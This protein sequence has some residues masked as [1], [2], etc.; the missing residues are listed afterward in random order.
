MGL[1]PLQYAAANNRNAAV[2][3]ALLDAGAD[4]EAKSSFGPPPLMLA[5]IESN[6]EAIRLL[7]CPVGVTQTALFEHQSGAP[8]MR[9]KWKKNCAV[10]LMPTRKKNMLV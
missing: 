7:S 9:H 8:L 2:I 10:V 5:E 4:V 6:E 3:Q 1:T